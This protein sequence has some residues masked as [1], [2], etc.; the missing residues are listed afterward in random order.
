MICEG[1]QVVKRASLSISEPNEKWIQAQVD[2][3]A[4][5]SRSEVLNDLI[6]KAR[7]TETIRTRLKS[8]ERSVKERG[9]VTKTPEE[10]LGGF[11]EKARRDG[12][13]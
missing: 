7:A 9:W 6:R 3:K 11:R 1:Q 13:L 5:S 4:F 10:L 12:D 2:S 8:A